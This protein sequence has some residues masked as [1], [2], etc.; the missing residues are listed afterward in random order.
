MKKLILTTVAALTIAANVSAQTGYDDT[1][2]E[3]AIRYGIAPNSKWLNH[4]GV[5]SVAFGGCEYDN[6]NHTGSFSAEYFY[7][8]KEKLGIGC[9]LAYGKNKGDYDYGLNDYGKTE[10]SYYTFM[11]AVKFDYLR[12]ENFGMYSKFALGVTMTSG[13]Y[14]YND[15]TTKDCTDY[16]LNFQASFIGIE[17]GSPYLRGFTEL[18]IGEQGVLSIGIRYKF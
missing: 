7:H 17:A 13:T 15:G 16:S 10:A 12:K 11:P 4:V 2:H 6:L 14:K 18:G 9:V 1:K 5:F 3:V 8:S